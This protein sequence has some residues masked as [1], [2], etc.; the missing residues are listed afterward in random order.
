MSENH[1]LLQ[2]QLKKVG[3]N[4]DGSEV[5]DAESWQKLLA[6]VSQAYLEADN[7]RYKLR[8]SLEVSS[9]EMREL[10]ED[11]LAQKQRAE[12]ASQAKGIFLAQMSHEIRTPMNGVLGMASLLDKTS[13]NDEQRHYLDVIQTSAETLLTVINDILDFSKVEAGKMELSETSFRL[14]QQI[15][16]VTSLLAQRAHAKGVELACLVYHEVPDLLIGDP[17]RLRQV[18]TNLIGNSVKFTEQGEVV[19]RVKIKEQDDNLVTLLVEVSD[20]GLGVPEELQESIFQPFSQ[21]DSTTTRRFGGT[22]LGLP[23]CKH[24]VGLMGGEMGLKSRPGEGSTFWFTVP[25]KRSGEKK[26]EVGPEDE[27]FGLRVLIIDDNETNRTI[28]RQELMNRDITTKDAASGAEGLELLSKAAR[29]RV[30]FDLVILDMQMPDMDGLE[31]AQRIRSGE[32]SPEVPIVLLT[33]IG[34]GDWEKKAADVG[35]DAFHQKPIRPENLFHAIRKVVALDEV[36]EEPEVAPVPRPSKNSSARR[37]CGTVLVVEDNFFNQQVALGLLTK[38]GLKS[39]AVDDGESALELLW[40]ESF[41]LILMDC[42]MPG[43]DGYECTREIRKRESTGVRTPIVALTAHAMAEEKERCFQNGMDDYLSK[44][45]TLEELSKCLSRWLPV[46]GENPPPSV[47]QVTAKH[48]DPVTFETLRELRKQNLAA[49]LPDLFDVFVNEMENVMERLRAAVA[50]KDL[51]SIKEAAHSLKGVAGNFGAK[52]ML[53]LVER[54][55]PLDQSAIGELE[56]AFTG[57]KRV[58]AEQARTV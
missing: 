22:G 25:L 12:E 14:R 10:N 34:K 28:L 7:D 43:V 18:L 54:E 44:P 20:T 40:K 51:Y 9:Q 37:Y 39:K 17:D 41:D 46:E 48:I 56:E 16:G 55:R 24:L 19:V 35:I 23:I 5:P 45:V 30:P 49:G 13:L 26:E 2:R 29:R 47:E 33:S 32:D 58:I 36:N 21:A 31:V 6:R 50:E 38:L 1:R 15:E 53:A 4:P 3:L 27:L 57:L 42:Q 8:R 52:R 11:L